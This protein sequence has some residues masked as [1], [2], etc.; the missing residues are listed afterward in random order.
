[1]S[2]FLPVASWSYSKI[3]RF[4]LFL[5]DSIIV[6]RSLTPHRF[7]KDRN[8]FSFQAG[9]L[10]IPHDGIF[11][12]KTSEYEEIFEVIDSFIHRRVAPENLVNRVYINEDM[13]AVLTGTSIY[14]SWCR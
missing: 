2:T 14:G 7:G 3:L 12:F 4:Y 11:Y 10:A 1:M 6:Q 9:K 13:K 8:V 5:S